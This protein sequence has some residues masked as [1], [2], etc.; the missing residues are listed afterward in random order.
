MKPPRVGDRVLVHVRGIV[1]QAGKQPVY[2]DKK[3]YFMEM[4]H[5][6]VEIEHGKKSLGEM[7][8][9]DGKV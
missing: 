5:D 2:S 7:E 4:E 6:G 3:G 8:R 1:T 9:E